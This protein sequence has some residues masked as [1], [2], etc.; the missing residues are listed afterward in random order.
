MANG[1]IIIKRNISRD[2]APPGRVSNK[3]VYKSI[4]LDSL[5]EIYSLSM[6]SDVILI[7]AGTYDIGSSSI[8]LKNGVD[9]EFTTGVTINGSNA[10]SLFYDDGED[11]NIQ[12]G[13]KPTLVNSVG[14]GIV[15]TGNS[16]IKRDS[17]DTFPHK[18]LVKNEAGDGY[19]FRYMV[20]PDN[21]N[22]DNDGLSW[23]KAKVSIKGVL[24]VLPYD[25]EGYIAHI[26]VKS[27]TYSALDMSKSNGTIYFYWVGTNF[28]V[29]P[30]NDRMIWLLNGETVVRDANPIIFDTAIPGQG[31]VSHYIDCSNITIQFYAIDKDDKVYRRSW[32]FTDTVAGHSRL[33]WVAGLGTYVRADAF[34]FYMALNAAQG[35]TAETGTEVQLDSPEF[36]GGTGAGSTSVGEWYGAIWGDGASKLMNL[37]K[38]GGGMSSASGFAAKFEN[39]IYIEDIRQ[40]INLRNYENFSNSNGIGV[41]YADVVQT[42]GSTIIKIQAGAKNCHIKYD[43]TKCTIDGTPLG[44]FVLEDTDSGV[45]KDYI[46]GDLVDNGTNLLYK[47]NIVQTA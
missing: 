33:F 22:D 9:W 16:F 41:D 10:T 7:T 30:L 2:T 1:G 43:G 19:A 6:A 31:W 32:R 8:K 34:A 38:V 20:D 44:A 37:G 3:R 23:A 36:Y 35:I 25:L 4:I 11:I 17:Y 5:S 26:A 27:G 45:R 42:Y 46:T 24:D 13:G 14:S 28:D 40:G 15:L 21:G 29:T 47:G 39:G 12:W 18:D